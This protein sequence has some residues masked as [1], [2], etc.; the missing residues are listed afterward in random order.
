M[1]FLHWIS[2]T[3]AGE[4]ILHL[5]FVRFYIVF[6]LAARN[7][8][9]LRYMIFEEFGESST[10]KITTYVKC[11]LKLP[12]LLSP[13]QDSRSVTIPKICPPFYLSS[14]SI[15]ETPN[16]IAPKKSKGCSEKQ[17]L[18]RQHAAGG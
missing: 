4:V 18:S 16:L 15:P 8:I 13:S 1:S 11:H 2:N 9:Y 14:G 7:L 17:P 6:S 10:R 3:F 12:P 5:H